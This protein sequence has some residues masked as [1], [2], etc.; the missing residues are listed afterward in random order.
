MVRLGGFGLDGRVLVFSLGVSVATSLLVGLLPALEVRKLSFY[1]LTAGQ[2]S[3]TAGKQRVRQAFIAGQVTLTVVL[4]ACSGLLLRT[5]VYLQTLP[6]GFDP[7]SVMTA[8]LSLDDAPYR[9]S[10]ALPRFV[11]QS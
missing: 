2:R 9:A 6:S 3:V 10:A 8:Q 4:L 7:T 5:L 11:H 1:G